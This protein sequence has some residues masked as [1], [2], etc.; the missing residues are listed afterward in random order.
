MGSG[1]E[2]RRSI[3]CVVSLLFCAL[4]ALGTA[5]EIRVT[6]TRHWDTF[7]VQATALIQ[8][9]VADA[10]N[11][12]TDYGRLAE[13]IPGLQESRVISRNG[14]NVVVDQSGEARLLFFRFPMRV[15][16]AITEFPHD[17][18]VSRAIAG[19]FKQLQ[20]IYR[21]EARGKSMQLRYDGNF[22]PDFE[23]PPFIGTLV[24]RNTLEK[25]F[26]ALV[27]EIEKTRHGTMPGKK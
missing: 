24:V 3:V 18:I 16:L 2:A 1:A 14:S 27:R 10:W 11:V 5:A 8:A 15:R 21:L 20:G 12:V 26:A 19:N 22:T 9:D 17:R 6:T 25:R 23:L 7:E 13:Y 4:P